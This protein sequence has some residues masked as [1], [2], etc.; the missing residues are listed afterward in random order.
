MPF[1][2]VIP[3]LQIYPVNYWH[4]CIRPYT[5]AWGPTTK[6]KSPFLGTG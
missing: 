3:L 2:P 5:R 6:G 4:A 1:D